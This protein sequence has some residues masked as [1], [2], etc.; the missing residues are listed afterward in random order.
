[1]AVDGFD[2]VLVAGYG[3]ASWGSPV[4]AYTS[5]TDAYAAKL[6]SAGALTWN[7]FLG[8][9]SQ[10]QGQGIAT[11]SGGGVYVTGMSLASWSAGECDGCPLRALSAGFDAFA[12]KLSDGGT[13]RIE[14]VTSPASASST[15]GFQSDVNGTF[16]VLGHGQSRTFAGIDTGSYRV[17]EVDPTPDYL[18]ASI[19]C[20]DGG[21]AMPSTVGILTATIHVEEG[22][23]VTCVF[24]NTPKREL[25]TGIDLVRLQADT[26]PDG[27]VAVAWETGTEHDVL[28]FHV[29]RAAARQGPFTRLTPRLIAARGPAGRGATYRFVEAPGRGVHYYRLVLIRAGAAPGI[30]GPVAARVDALRAFLPLAGALR[31]GPGR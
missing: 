2:N 16:F 25:P 6:S 4:R 23:T 30:A 13:I 10:D 21:S 29:E 19:A 12:T 22:E 1:V 24:T 5:G 20:D 18:L 27:R 31:R 3:S 14:K 17:S 9:G 11:D 8:S 15:F 26:L 28:G 7:L